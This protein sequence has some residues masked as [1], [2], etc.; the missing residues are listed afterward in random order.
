[1]SVSERN[2][3]ARGWLGGAAELGTSA[4][5]KQSPKPLHDAQGAADDD[6]DNSG[7]NHSSDNEQR[8][9]LETVSCL[10]LSC[11]CKACRQAT[12]AG[13]LVHVMRRFLCNALLDG[14]IYFVR[15]AA[16]VC[17]AVDD[18]GVL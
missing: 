6:A 12:V 16:A 7:S 1:M 13:A 5:D 2:A 10:R 11:H 8:D 17:P 15:Y 9:V 4:I 14:T 18:H 3:L